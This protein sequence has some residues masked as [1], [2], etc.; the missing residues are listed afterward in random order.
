MAGQTQQS[1]RPLGLKRLGEMGFIHHQECSSVR[2]VSR[3]PSPAVQCELQIK[4]LRFALPVRVKPHRSNHHQAQWNSTQQSAGREQG[5]ER[6]AEAHLISEQRTTPC[7]QPAS[8]RTLMRKWSAAIGKRLIQICPGDQL[9][10]MG[11][12]WQR[13]TMP[14]QPAHQ[15][16]LN[17]KT[18]RKTVKQGFG[19]GQWKFPATFRTFPE[20]PRS[21][22]AH[23][24]VG[25]GIEWVRHP[26]K[27]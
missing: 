14:I 9:P 18:R 3:Q 12:R 20:P 11:Q 5:R 7:K 23:L 1:L 2:K 6:L 27:S 4:G 19:S 16:I 17:P 24:R 13:V 15:L 10:V 26:H 22:P 8:T 25:H 21:D